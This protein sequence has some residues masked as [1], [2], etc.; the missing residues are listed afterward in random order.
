MRLTFLRIIHQLNID[1]GQY[2]TIS[3]FYIVHSYCNFL[4]DRA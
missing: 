4:I 3:A 1:L 2:F